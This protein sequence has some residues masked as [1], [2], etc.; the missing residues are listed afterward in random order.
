MRVVHHA[1]NPVEAHLV[2]HALEADGVLVFV[3][4][5]SLAGGVGELPAGSFIQVAVPDGQ[6][7]AAEAVLREL[8]LLAGS[9]DDDALADDDGLGDAAGLTA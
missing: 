4:G 5:E 7:D 8:P 1:A 6:V 3:L 2:K 9:V